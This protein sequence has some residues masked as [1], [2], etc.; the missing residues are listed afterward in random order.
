MKTNLFHLL[1]DRHTHTHSMY[2]TTISSCPPTPFYPCLFTLSIRKKKNVLCNLQLLESGKICL[3]HA[4]HI[5]ISSSSDLYPAASQKQLLSRLQ[6]PDF[7]YWLF[8][9]MGRKGP[10]PVDAKLKKLEDR[11]TR[12][13]SLMTAQGWGKAIWIK[14][15]RIL[16]ELPFPEHHVRETLS[17]AL[18]WNF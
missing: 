3:R 2:L 8:G 12:S 17:L 14:P 9:G 18:L 7:S 15:A 11:D 5:S 4:K 16:H 10:T 1:Y 13:L 6:S